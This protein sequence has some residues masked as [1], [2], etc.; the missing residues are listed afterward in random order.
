MSAATDRYVDDLL[1]DIGADRHAVNAGA[2]VA[3]H[4]ARLE[5]LGPVRVVALE[6]C[7]RC[8]GNVIASTDVARCTRCDYTVA[9][10][11]R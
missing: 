1:V 11:H 2:L 6:P 3:R 4:A 5:E 9:G 10:G 8:A 7:P